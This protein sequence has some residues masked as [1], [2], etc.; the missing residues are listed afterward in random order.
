MSDPRPEPEQRAPAT[1]ARFEATIS[2]GEKRRSLEDVADLGLDRV[3]GPTGQVRLLI[4]TDD[5]VRLVDHGYEVN[6]KRALPVRPLDPG[7]VSDDGS[8]KA[9]LEEQVRGIDRQGT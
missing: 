7:L 3:P 5:L 2:P 8:D 1:T 9:W 4:T 6:V